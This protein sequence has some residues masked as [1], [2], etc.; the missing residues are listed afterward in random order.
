MANV[1]NGADGDFSEELIILRYNTGLANDLGNMVNRSLNMIEKYFDGRAPV[2]DKNTADEKM[3]AAVKGVDSL[4]PVYNEK[5]EKFDFSGALS[6]VWK[7][8]NTANKL[9][10]DEAPWTLA[11]EGNTAKLGSVMYILLEIIRVASAAIAPVMPETAAKIWEKTGSGYTEE[12]LR[13]PEKIK[14]G[15]TAEGTQVKK[16]DPLFPRIKDEEKK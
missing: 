3:N 1:T 7:L 16:G 9:I 10:E 15:L 12:K 14:F 8:I 5:M 13:L 4:W 6:E 2:Y 11:K